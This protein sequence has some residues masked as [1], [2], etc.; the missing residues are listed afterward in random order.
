[1]EEEQSFTSY[2]LCSLSH[3][4]FHPHPTPSS[5]SPH[6]LLSLI[7]PSSLSPPKLQAHHTCSTSHTSP[8]NLIPHTPTCP[9]GTPSSSNL[10]GTGDYGHS[11]RKDT[12][13][14]IPNLLEWQWEWGKCTCMTYIIIN[15]IQYKQHMHTH[16][17]T[18]GKPF[19]PSL[20]LTCLPSCI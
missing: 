8:H 18:H 20:L 7:P 10:S 13:D 6:T 2:F 5:A 4:H 14:P 1:M 17:H 16:V 3:C 15:N 12:L 11:M 19:P 9:S